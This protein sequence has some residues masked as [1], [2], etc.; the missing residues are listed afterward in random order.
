MIGL[1]SN[2]KQMENYS[3]FCTYSLVSS[4][5]WCFSG[6]I[7]IPSTLPIRLVCDYS[8]YHFINCRRPVGSI[9]WDLS[10]FLMSVIC[11]PSFFLFVSLSRNSPAPLVF[12]ENPL[13]A[14]FI[15][16][17]AYMCSTALISALYCF[18]GLIYFSTF[19]RWILKLMIFHIFL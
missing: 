12:S 6:S 5:S 2:T 11:G 15:L 8:Y 19:L 14:L 10:S 17:T 7:S 4:D 9:V 1:I 13:L 16:S 18:T 3:D